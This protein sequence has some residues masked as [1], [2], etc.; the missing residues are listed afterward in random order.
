[1]SHSQREERPTR[2]RE[3]G[4]TLC[5]PRACRWTSGDRQSLVLGDGE[6]AVLKNASVSFRPGVVTAEDRVAYRDTQ[7]VS[8]QFRR[9][10][11]TQPVAVQTDLREAASTF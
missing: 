10:R 11:R 9:P 4:S 7:P 2:P 3:R 1:T 6:L 8:D 5:T